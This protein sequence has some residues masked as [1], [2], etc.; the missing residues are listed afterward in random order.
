MKYKRDDDLG[1]CKVCKLCTY[2]Q[3][4]KDMHAW[5]YN[6]E[7]KKFEKVQFTSKLQIIKR[8]L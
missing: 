6:F 1:T 4:T 5:I 3:W 2:R 7:I 8:L